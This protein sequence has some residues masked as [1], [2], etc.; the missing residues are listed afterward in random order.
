MAQVRSARAINRV[1]KNEDSDIF[2]ISLGT[3]RDGKI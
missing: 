3:N 1:E 2:I